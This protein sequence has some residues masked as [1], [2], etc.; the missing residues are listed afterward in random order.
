MGSIQW[1]KCIGIYCYYW[2]NEEKPANHLLRVVQFY[3]VRNNSSYHEQSCLYNKINSKFI[4]EKCLY[5]G[6]YTKAKFFETMI[7]YKGNNRQSMSLIW[8][9]SVLE[10]QLEV[11]IF[12]VMNK[13]LKVIIS[14]IILIS[15]YHYD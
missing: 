4:D 11:F 14:H 5:Y 12:E 13:V 15:V 7:S 1:N 10:N 6:S 9:Y 3:C 8:I 2:E